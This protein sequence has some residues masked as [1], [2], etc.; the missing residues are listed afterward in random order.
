MFIL[1]GY[2]DYRCVVEF[3]VMQGKERTVFDSLSSENQ[4]EK[5]SENPS[6][7]LFLFGGGD[8]TGK[9]YN[10]AYVLNV[11]RQ[12]WIKVSKQNDAVCFESVHNGKEKQ[13][14]PRTSH[15]AVVYNNCVFVFGGQWF[16]VA[17]VERK[18]IFFSDLWKFDLA[19]MEWTFI[20][21]ENAPSRG[22]HTCS[23]IESRL[24]MVGGSN[25]DGPFADVWML[26]LSSN[27]LVW[28][29]VSVSKYEGFEMHCTLT[30][31]L[32][33]YIFGGRGEEVFCRFLE[34]KTLS[35]EW[36]LHDECFPLCGSSAILMDG[37]AIFVGGTDC[38]QFFSTMYIYDTM[39][40]VWIQEPSGI[41]PRI[42]H[43]FV[44]IDNTRAILFGG[45]GID[46]EFNTTYLFID[47]EKTKLQ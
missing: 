15:S 30:S 12:A 28:V 11:K 38:T 5:N 18:P 36:V 44:K 33:L 41:E 16:D 39:N 9:F 31:G 45:S 40:A 14:H 32:S 4:N 6:L 26:D 37:R 2:V 3:P 19:K 42:A 27:N 17:D 7:S 24:F 21:A 35:N 8:R 13:P 10:D 46:Q 34:F 29:N 25:Q 47:S 20:N 1:I 22:S 43:S 23:I